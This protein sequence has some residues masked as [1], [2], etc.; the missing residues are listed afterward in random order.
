[1]WIIC[2][3]KRWIWKRS[4]EWDHS[5][6]KLVLYHKM[7]IKVMFMRSSFSKVEK[8][9]QNDEVVS[10]TH[11]HSLRFFLVF[12]LGQYLFVPMEILKYACHSIR[13]NFVKTKTDRTFCFVYFSFFLLLK[14]M[15][16][17]HWKTFIFHLFHS[18]I[19]VCLFW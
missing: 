8:P 17:F 9:N 6:W 4:H 14:F 16:T 18:L 13:I 1:M 5:F 11:C 15:P 10:F 3:W 12:N 2:N 19:G 7:Y